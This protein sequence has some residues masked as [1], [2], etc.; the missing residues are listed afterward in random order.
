MTD[1]S[2]VTGPLSVSLAVSDLE[3][4]DGVMEP[5]L[6][7]HGLVRGYEFCLPVENAMLIL[8]E[9]QQASVKRMIAKLYQHARSS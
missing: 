5:V 9:T 4:P 2:S 1:M 3:D 6:R 7:V 8:D